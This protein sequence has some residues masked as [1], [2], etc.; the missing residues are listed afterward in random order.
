MVSR[1]TEKEGEKKKREKK[2][3]KTNVWGGGMIASSFIVIIFRSSLPKR[4]G[5]FQSPRPARSVCVLSKKKIIQYTKT[6]S[7]D[8]H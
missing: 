2:E 1:T 5:G 3:T 7:I 8:Y 6:K 4:N